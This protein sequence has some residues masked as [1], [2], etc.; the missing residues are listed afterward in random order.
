MFRKMYHALDVHRLGQMGQMDLPVCKSQGPP[1]LVLLRIIIYKSCSSRRSIVVRSHQWRSA[2]I[3]H[4]VCTFY[5][6]AWRHCQGYAS[7]DQAS[8]LTDKLV[9]G[10]QLTPCGASSELSYL[11]SAGDSRANGSKVHAVAQGCKATDDLCLAGVVPWQVLDNMIYVLKSSVTAD[12]RWTKH[13]YQAPRPRVAQTRASGRESCRGKCR[14]PQ[15]AGN[16]QRVLIQRSASL[17]PLSQAS[18]ADGPLCPKTVW[19]KDL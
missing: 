8:S 16:E 3:K 11:T 9:T 18:R 19:S 13:E 10:G 1:E 12:W 17:A 5:I 4:Q 6:N 14:A 7:G 2:Q 15:S